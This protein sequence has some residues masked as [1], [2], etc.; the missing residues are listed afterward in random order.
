MKAIVALQLEAD[1][2]HTWIT[3]KLAAEERG[4]DTIEKVLWAAGVIVIVGIVYAAI[5]SYVN[6]KVGSIK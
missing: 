4:S 3:N 2:V 6:T 1:R 5:T